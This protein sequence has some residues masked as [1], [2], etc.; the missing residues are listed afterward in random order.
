[1]STVHLGLSGCDE[2]CYIYL[3]LLLQLRAQLRGA[4]GSYMES[5][6][7]SSVGTTTGWSLV[8]TSPTTTPE[9]EGSGTKR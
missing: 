8:R 7:N 9:A 2:M 1:M 4:T 6:R 3:V 5:M